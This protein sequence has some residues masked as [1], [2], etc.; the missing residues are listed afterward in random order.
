MA[1]APTSPRAALLAAL[2]EA[3]AALSFAMTATMQATEQGV[4]AD[5]ID[6]LQ[7]DLQVKLTEVE[8][9]IR[10]HG[11]LTDIVTGPTSEQV[12]ALRASV[13]ALRNQNV[14]A[15]AWKGIVE[16]ALA[17]SAQVFNLPGAAQLATASEPAAA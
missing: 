9:R 10:A 4:S 2:Y 11:S 8:K 6:E 12:A 3:Q 14:T 1:T 7:S 16:D 15:A 17:I 13:V 5:E